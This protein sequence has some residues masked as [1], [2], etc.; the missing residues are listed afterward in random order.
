LFRRFG[1]HEFKPEQIELFNRWLYTP[2]TDGKPRVLIIPPDDIC[3]FPSNVLHFIDDI[4]QVFIFSIYN[5]KGININW[6]TK[7]L[8]EKFFLAKTFNQ[9]TLFLSYFSMF[10]IKKYMPIFIRDKVPFFTKLFFTRV[11]LLTHC[12]VFS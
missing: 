11:S 10:L 2:R 8:W 9:L 1:S 6:E 12:K 3:Y 4:K 5:K 7:S